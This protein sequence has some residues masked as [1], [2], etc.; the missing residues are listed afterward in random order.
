[1]PSLDT[2]KQTTV[3]VVNNQQTNIPKANGSAIER[4]CLNF[5]VKHVRGN[6]VNS[7][8]PCISGKLAGNIVPVRIIL[9][10]GCQ[11]GTRPRSVSFPA[12]R[13]TPREP[14]RNFSL[15]LSLPLFLSLSFSLS[16]YR[17]SLPLVFRQIPTTC[18]LFNAA[19]AR[20]PREG[21]FVRYRRALIQILL[22]AKVP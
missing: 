20:N 3:R 15:S 22:R 18:F 6:P 2:I 17:F 14:R 21:I 11:G 10:K 8:S 12:A 9:T 16:L 7:R 1:M 13:K 4:F 19:A 5:T